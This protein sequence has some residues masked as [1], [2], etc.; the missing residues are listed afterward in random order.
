VSDDVFIQPLKLSDFVASAPGDS[1]G[2]TQLVQDVLGTSGSALD[3]FDAALTDVSTSVDL[4]DAALGQQDAALDAVLVSLSATDPA[5]LDQSMAG[6]ASTIGTGEGLVNDAN[7]LTPPDLLILP[8]SPTFGGLVGPP[9]QQKTIDLGTHHVGDA[10]W[11]YLLGTWSTHIGRVML[12]SG[13]QSDTLSHGDSRIFA[14]RQ[15]I[16]MDQ[17]SKDNIDRAGYDELVIT[18]AIAGNWIAQVSGFGG[19]FGTGTIFTY[20]LTLLP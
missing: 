13:I 5:P 19:P 4:L 1:P 15:I 8:I 11:T 14:L 12:H 7:N 20:T 2:F 9:P 10:P 18:P 17:H 6:Y 3:G 16:T